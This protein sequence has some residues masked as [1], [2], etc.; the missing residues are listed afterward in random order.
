MAE[1]WACRNVVDNRAGALKVLRRGIDAD[2]LARFQR[3]MLALGKLRHRAIVGLL[4]HD[5]TSPERPWLVMEKVDGVTLWSAID[6][7]PMPIAACLRPFSALADGLAQA[8]AYGVH[9]RDVKSENVILRPNGSMV[10]VDF[11]AAIDDDSSEV[12]RA[13]LMLG[14]TRYLPPEVVGG[15]ERD[16]VLA[17]VYALGMLL[18]ECLTG[19][20]AFTTEGGPSRSILRLKVHMRHLDPGRGFPNDVRK[21]IRQCT[22]ADPD[23]RINRME[24]L[25]DMLEV[26]SGADG[27]TPL[28]SLR[29]SARLNQLKRNAAPNGP[30][31]LENADF[32]WPPDQ[33]PESPSFDAPTQLIR[34]QE[35]A[36]KP[37]QETRRGKWLVVGA[38]FFGVTLLMGAGA[39]F[40]LSQGWLSYGR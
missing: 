27:A 10:L 35:I 28:M 23:R 30:D 6:H 25:A 7:G 20:H 19:Q 14:T 12:T 29:Q 39:V 34:P 1:V 2:D 18:H 24:D 13:G 33:V 38:L 31:S 26:A 32:V 37:P 5:L 40:T 4:D 36:P 17:D 16:N 9:H 15:E 8:H 11:G 21:I 22:A 3:E